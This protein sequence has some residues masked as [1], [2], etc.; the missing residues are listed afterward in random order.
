MSYRNSFRTVMASDALIGT[1]GE[2]HAQDKLKI[3][4]IA[5]LSGP[6]AVLGAKCATGSL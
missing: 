4:I 5:T 6:S 3:G 1:A 2:A